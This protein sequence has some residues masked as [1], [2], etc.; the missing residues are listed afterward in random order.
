VLHGPSLIFAYLQAHFMRF[1][2][3]AV[4]VVVLLSYH[5]IFEP[6]SRTQTTYVPKSQRS[7]YR[8]Y[9]SMFLKS[10]LKIL[11]KIDEQIS[12]IRTKRRRITCHHF[13]YLKRKRPKVFRKPGYQMYQAT[14][15]FHPEAHKMRFDT[16]SK[17]L[18]VDN[19]AS[20]CMSSHIEDF[21]DVPK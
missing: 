4:S 19:G 15:G 1:L 6:D 14:D 11:K 20:R 21:V 10:W 8:R 2:W 5:T 13:T 17:N 3:F 9:F 18:R 12:Q 16:D 7:K